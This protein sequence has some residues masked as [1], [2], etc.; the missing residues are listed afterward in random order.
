MK[1]YNLN[2][3]NLTSEYCY[4][5]SPFGLGDTY[6]L[7]ALKQALEQKYNIKIYFLIKKSHEIIMKMFGIDDY[8]I[9]SFSLDECKKIANQHQLPQAGE[10]FVAH[11]KF[12]KKGKKLIKK[13]KKLAYAFLDMYFDFFELKKD[14]QLVKPQWY[15]QVTEDLQKKLPASIKD[16]VLLLP[17]ANSLKN[18][19]VKFWLNIVEKENAEKHVVIQNV[20]QHEN[21]IPNILNIDLSVEELLALCLNCAKVYSIR[22]G[23]CDLFSLKISDAVVYYPTV[24]DLYNYSL[25]TLGKVSVQ[26]EIVDSNYI[27]GH[28]KIFSFLLF[29]CIPFIKIKISK[30]ETKVCFCNI[31][32]LSIKK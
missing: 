25:K 15:P 14:I 5:L 19:D 7:C 3:I 16:I 18:F 21:E 10:L 11:M 27:R 20:L 30:N 8:K 24:Q 12:Y 2:E 17:E 9:V 6:I 32:I 26:E 29:F 22:S 23:I 31:P 13:F 4:F 1:T 28:K